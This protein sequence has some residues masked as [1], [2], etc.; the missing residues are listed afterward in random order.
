MK[1]LN[2]KID[3]WERKKNAATTN[4]EWESYDES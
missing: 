1:Q 4:D 2:D 3:E